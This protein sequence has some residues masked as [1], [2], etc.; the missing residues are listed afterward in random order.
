MSICVLLVDHSE[1]HCRALM[2]VLKSLGVDY[3][4]YCR[5]AE[6]ALA[7]L[8][9]NP[10]AWDA[11][12][13]DLQFVDQCMGGIEFFHLLGDLKYRGGVVL[14]SSG[15]DAMSSFAV[16]L[17]VPFRLRVLGSLSKP[18]TESAVAFLIRRVRHCCPGAAHRPKSLLRRSQV[19]GALEQS[20]LVPYFQPIVDF[21]NRRL[22]GL[23]CL[24]RL[25][26]EGRGTV[27][28]SAFIAVAERF[29]LINAMTVSMLNSVLPQYRFFKERTGE[30]CQ[31][32]V[33][34][35]PLQLNDSGTPGLLHECLLKNNVDP[36]QVV[37]EVVDN[38]REGEVGYGD[39]IARLR[40]LGF[41]VALG[42][43]GAGYTDVCA[44]RLLPYTQI[45]LDRQMVEGVGSDAVLHS[46]AQ[47]AFKQTR[48]LG[49]PLISEGVEKTADLEVL[50]GI[51][52]RYFQGYLLCRP[53]LLGDLIRWHS[54]WRETTD[55]G[56]GKSH[57][58]T[59]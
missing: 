31:L 41:G 57:W 18:F 50:S 5:D 58:L 36:Q 24:I 23:E 6:S 7:K 16:E 17:I 1:A 9:R 12:M 42:S 33:N 51:G 48:E 30:E 52:I 26:I 32:S 29:N 44:S 25:D 13:V 14:M 46:M 3:V 2:A 10:D 59:H 4:D 49:L 21:T 35:S 37:F 8:G 40:K 11:I 55:S 38:E 56:R 22:F 15:D 34:L 39:G 28:P 20:R 47:N 54:D 27:L 19:E 43:F 53:K 45:K